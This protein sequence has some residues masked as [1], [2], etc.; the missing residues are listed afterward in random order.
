MIEY[1]YHERVMKM[2]ALKAGEH[3]QMGSCWTGYKR[4]LLFF[5]VMRAKSREK[6]EKA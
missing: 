4:E 5:G 3:Q 1:L 2:Y 6:R